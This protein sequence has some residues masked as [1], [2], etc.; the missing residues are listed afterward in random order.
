ME[1]LFAEA[2]KCGNMNGAVYWDRFADGLQMMLHEPYSSNL[3]RDLDFRSLYNGYAEAM[4]FVLGLNSMGYVAED[5]LPKRDES[6]R[7][8]IIEE[9]NSCL[10]R[11]NLGTE[12][13]GEIVAS[14]H[15]LLEKPGVERVYLDDLPVAVLIQ[16]RLAEFY[17]SNRQ[18]EMFDS[19]MR[20]IK[21]FLTEHG[22]VSYKGIFRYSAE[23]ETDAGIL[24]QLSNMIRNREVDTNMLICA[25]RL[26]VN[27]VGW[28][29]ELYEFIGNRNQERMPELQKRIFSLIAP[30]D[31]N[32][33]QMKYYLFVLIQMKKRFHTMNI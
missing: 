33:V 9:L 30:E 21:A 25:I 17:F 12:D 4:E 10:R 8:Q 2:Y 3:R 11:W 18:W 29:W 7:T 28:L 13:K 31:N 15:H 5:I 26:V 23:L 22:S 32:S 27:P 1:E 6:I 19:F 24:E 14:M 16:F 20:E